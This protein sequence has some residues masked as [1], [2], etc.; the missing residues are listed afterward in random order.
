MTSNPNGIAIKMSATLPIICDETRSSFALVF[1]RKYLLV[2]LRFTTSSFFS[3]F[4]F[5]VCSGPDKSSKEKHLH[6]VLF[7]S[8]FGIS[9]ALVL[10]AI[11]VVCKLFKL[12][13]WVSVEILVEYI[14]AF[15]SVFV[16]IV[17]CVDLVDPEFFGTAEL[18]V[19]ELSVSDVLQ[20]LISDK[21]IKLG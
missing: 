15:V 12:E 6:K 3:S 13:I 18:D 14:T 9:L 10:L 17:D 20:I 1:D 16:E 7:C 4:T 11:E 2:S 8:S 19:K 21:E 5:S